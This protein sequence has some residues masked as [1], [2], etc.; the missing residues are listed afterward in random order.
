MMIFIW[1]IEGMGVI[2]ERGRER[3]RR[4]IESRGFIFLGGLDWISRLRV[5]RVIC[6]CS[7]VC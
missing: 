2:K 7:F 1:G 6:A 3:G 4:V 5:S